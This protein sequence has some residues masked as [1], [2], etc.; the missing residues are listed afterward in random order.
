MLLD[1]QDFRRKVSG[2]DAMSGAPI[3]I[4]RPAL[5]PDRFCFLHGA[6]IGP[7][8]GRARLPGRM[9]GAMPII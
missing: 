7:D 5:K 9:I 4:L 1:P 2:A 6:L 8:D 3:N